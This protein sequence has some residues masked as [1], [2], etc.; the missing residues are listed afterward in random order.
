MII[1]KLLYTIGLFIIP[2]VYTQNTQSFQSSFR[3]SEY[4]DQGYKVIQNH[5][6]PGY[7]LRLKEPTSCEEGIQ[8]SGY[9]DKHDSDDHFFFYF[10]ESRTDPETDPTL[11]WLNGGPGCSSMLGLWM[12]LGPCQVNS[13]GNDTIRNPYSWN[14]A[15]NILF[16]DQPVNV[17]YSYGKSKIR[18]TKDSARDIYAFLQLFFKE[19]PQYGAN[20]FH[21]SGE[22][23]AGHY[24]PAISSE[25]IKGNKKALDNNHLVINYE[26]M[27]IGNGWT[28]PRTQFEAYQIFGCSNDSKYKPLFNET[29]CNKMK[30]S[31]PRCKKMM[32]SCYKFPHAITCIPANLYCENT[33]TGPFSE[34][35][36]NPYDIR[37]KCDEDTDGC[38]IIMNSI[39]KYADSDEVKDS[40]GVAKEVS[41]F[42]SCSNSVGYR[43][44]QTGDGAKDFTSNVAD[45]LESGIRVLLYA[46][47]MDWICNWVGNLEWSLKMDWS[48]RDG[49]NDAQSLPYYSDLTGQHAGDVRTYDKLTFLKVFNAGHMVPYDQPQ[50]SLDFLNKW[51]SNLSLVE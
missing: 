29:T 30:D 21:I 41:K 40:L 35:D 20:A 33:Q 1:S 51:I 47:D 9:I 43:F 15:A 14:T 8:Y 44:Y 3:L 42:E 34:T 31:Y 23:Y 37:R 36:L 24:L 39:E 11:L 18:S 49:Y 22:S 26:S 32:D 27:L 2:A 19:Y 12:E 38:Y 6:I 45:T 48:G 13:Y 4:A 10:F 28:D 7:S 5:L 25:I 46:G 16:V 50:N 17:G